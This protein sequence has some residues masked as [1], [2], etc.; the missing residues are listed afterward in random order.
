VV[1]PV[2]NSRTLSAEI[3]QQ[4]TTT[5]RGQV[6]THTVLVDRPLAKGGSDHGPMGGE[7]LLIALGGCFLSNLLA[8]IRTRE[9]SVDAIEIVVDGRIEG[10]PERMTHFRLN[11]RARYD[12]RAEMEKLLIIA[13]RGC[14]VSNT[15]RG[16][17]PIEVVLLDS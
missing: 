13:E 17:A 5:S 14:I 1:D 8:A 4:G 15:L 12:D 10:T 3:R 6:R 2:S 7:L 9:S 16:T 11:V